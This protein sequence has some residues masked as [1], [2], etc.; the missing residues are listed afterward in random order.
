MKRKNKM[1]NKNVN[2]QEKPEFC[3]DLVGFGAPKLFR[4]III[5]EFGVDLVGF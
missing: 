1:D 4:I 5:F 3:V 2:K